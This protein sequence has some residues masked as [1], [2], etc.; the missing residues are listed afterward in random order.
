[1]LL[2]SS[3]TCLAL[4]S[5]HGPA[6]TMKRARYSGSFDSFGSSSAGAAPADVT[7]IANFRKQLFTWLCLGSITAAQVATICYFATVLG[8]S[9]V[10]DLSVN[11]EQAS[12]NGS[13][14]IKLVLGK[15]FADPSLQYVRSVP[16]YD[17]MSGQRSQADIPFMPP[18]EVF[19]EQ[20]ENHSD[21]EAELI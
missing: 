7:Q 6:L 11:P 3:T 13:R 19:K 8:A 5:E 17:K 14:R 10:G 4:K 1:M 16:I 2:V 20:F 18:S 15:E 9:G 21:P 12:H